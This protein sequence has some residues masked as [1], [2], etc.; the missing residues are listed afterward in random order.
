M[1]LSKHVYSA[2]MLA[3]TLL[4]TAAYAQELKP[5]PHDPGNW[6]RN[7]LPVDESLFPEAYGIMGSEP[8]LY[9]VDLSEWPVKIDRSHQLFVDDYLIASTSNIQ[10]QFHKLKQRPRNPIFTPKKSMS[11]PFF[12][13]REETGKFRMWYI[14]RGSYIDKDGNR[15]RLPSAY[16]ESDDG[17]HWREPDLGLIEA[18]GSKHNNLVHHKALE[19]I[20][21]EPWE[22]DPQRR[23][24]ALVHHEPDNDQNQPEP[25]EGYWLNVSPDGIHWTRAHKY[26]SMTS[27]TGYLMPQPGI[28]DTSSFRWDPVL[29]K[30]ICNAKFVLPGKYRAYGLCES[31]D[32]I[33]WTRP[34]MMFYRDALDPVGLQYYAHYTFNYESMWLGL[35][36]TMQYFEI[37]RNKKYWKHCQWQLSTSRDGRHFVRC[38]DRTPILPVAKTAD[39]WGGDY[40]CFANGGPIRMGDELWFYYSDR[41]HAYN[42]A[43]KP[44]E[45]GLINLGLAT[46]RV[47]GF[48]SLNADSTPGTVTTR[49]LTFSAG[50]LFVNAEIG[51]GGWIKTALL[52]P[53]KQPIE[54]YT[55]ED[56]VTVTKGGLAQSVK[57][58]KSDKLK[59]PEGEHI[60]LKFTLK[61]AKLYSFWIR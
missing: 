9:P 51:Q 42:T 13:M 31:D 35:L 24:K 47:D 40:P 43:P 53:D 60:R 52:A 5:V 23:F 27:L 15:R 59:L 29:K 4:L 49:P 54:N 20:I 50:K 16:I 7:K 55:V 6:N 38:A 58:Q 2:L 19:G 57:W 28:G 22:K 41:R 3:S 1:K 37:E 33:H 11:Y 61:N 30:Y 17:I 39:E 26:A 46:L 36:K 25:F 18:D 8:L 10:K 56:A 12:M 45:V 34:R 14:Q 44:A 32:L 48:A 21:Y